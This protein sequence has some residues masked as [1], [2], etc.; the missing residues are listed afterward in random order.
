LRFRRLI[1]QSGC[2]REYRLRSRMSAASI[3]SSVPHICPSSMVKES[4]FA[5]PTGRSSWALEP[6]SGCCRNH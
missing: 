4:V 2:S 1:W 6:A 5:F 3:C